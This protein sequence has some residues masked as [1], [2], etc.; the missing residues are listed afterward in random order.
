[1]AIA[2]DI[3]RLQAQEDRLSFSHF[4]ED[5]AFALGIIARDMAIAAN[6][7][8]VLDVSLWDRRLFY[9]SMV[10][11]TPDNPDWVRRKANVVRRF[12]KSSYAVGREISAGTREFGPA[13]GIYHSMASLMREGIVMTRGQ[14][15]PDVEARNAYTEHE[16]IFAAIEGGDPALA[17]REMDRHILLAARRLRFDMSDSH[18]LDGVEHAASIDSVGAHAG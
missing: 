7:S 14:D 15:A 18:R 8:I 1:M 5:T 13:F 4:D 6:Q 10:G 16:R 12:M 17:S 2:D 9:F 3:A 11:K